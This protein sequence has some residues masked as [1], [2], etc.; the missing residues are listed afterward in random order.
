MMLLQFS[1]NLIKY[2][3]IRSLTKDKD[4]RRSYKLSEGCG[5]FQTEILNILKETELISK[6]VKK[7]TDVS[8]YFE[9]KAALKG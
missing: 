3:F 2:E 7:E 4:S 5:V 6:S 8:L 1:N 9:N